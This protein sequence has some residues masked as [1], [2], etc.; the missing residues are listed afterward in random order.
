VTTALCLATEVWVG[1][2]AQAAGFIDLSV[3]VGML[4]AGGVYALLLRT[5]LAKGGRP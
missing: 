2:I 4:V 3:P 1:P 5:P